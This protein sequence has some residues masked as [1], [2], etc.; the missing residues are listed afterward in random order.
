MYIYLDDSN[1]RICM[2]ICFHV[3]QLHA[4]LR[5]YIRMFCQSL[6]TTRMLRWY[7]YECI[8]TYIEWCTY[9]CM[10]MYIEYTYIRMYT[11]SALCIYSYVFRWSKYTYIHMHLWTWAT[12]ILSWCY[13]YVHINAYTCTS[14]LKY[15]CKYTCS[16]NC[17][18]PLECWTGIMYMSIYMCTPA[19]LFWYDTNTCVFTYINMYKYSAN[20]AQG[21]WVLFEC[22]IKHVWFSYV[23]ECIHMYTSFWI[24][25]YRMN[26]SICI[27][28]FFAGCLGAIWILG[29]CS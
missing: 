17:W 21:A 26:F 10:F 2:Y 24:Y 8:F 22:C 28:C 14:I 18:A 4:C 15:L 23:N 1:T 20:S 11:S 19:H 9:E 29:W 3:L 25:M 16:V 5:V 7:T 12:Q 27:H 13:I 6:G